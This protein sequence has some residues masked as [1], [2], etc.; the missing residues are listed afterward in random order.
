MQVL[1]GLHEC[2]QEQL[3]PVLAA[4]STG[5]QLTGLQLYFRDSTQEMDGPGIGE[6]HLGDMQNILL[7]K[8][9][10]KL[11]QLQLLHVAGLEL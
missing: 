5:T 11:P 3:E 10:K 8:Y 6:E 7:H 9:L 1:V 2:G 4:I